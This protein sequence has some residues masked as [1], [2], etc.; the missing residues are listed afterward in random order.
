MVVCKGEAL[1]NESV[2]CGYEYDKRPA[3]CLRGLCVLPMMIGA[4]LPAEA[5]RQVHGGDVARL[6][7]GRAFK[8]EC[9]DGT[10]GR[11]Q[12]TQAGVI[13]VLYR[14][15]QG[16]QRRNRPRG[17][18]R[19]GRRNLPRLETV[20]R[21]RR[22]LLSG[23][24]R[25]RGPLPARAPVRPGATSARSNIHVAITSLAA[26]PRA[27]RAPPLRWGAAGTAGAGR[28]SRCRPAPGRAR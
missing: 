18:A 23:L 5:G 17:D 20:R 7:M 15:P 1:R 3:V 28:A 12:I 21:R 26:A 19:E 13:N 14:R 24:R 25:G 22:R 27:H 6:L 4:T 9:V 8:I 10:H 11:G 2:Q 16:Q